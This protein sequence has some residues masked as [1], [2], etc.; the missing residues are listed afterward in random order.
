[1]I[2]VRTITNIFSYVNNRKENHTLIKS[3]NKDRKLTFKYD[4]FSGFSCNFA[5]RGKN[6]DEKKKSTVNVL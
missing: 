1:M 5:L 2:S 3:Q 6:S 4:Y